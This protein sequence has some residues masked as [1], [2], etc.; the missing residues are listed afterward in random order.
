M[1]TFFLLRHG[2]TA[3]N[4]QRR[5]MGRL[6]IPLDRDGVEQARRLAKLI[7]ALELDAIY[8]S[9]LKRAMQTARLLARGNSLRVT[10]ER[11][12]TELAFGRWAG[13]CFDD[14]VQDPLYH[15]FLKSPL[16]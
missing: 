11:G 10:K 3:W 4:K 2:E 7:P 15:R 14:L 13:A 8:T 12:L 5:I 6:D 9:P 16:T 1:E